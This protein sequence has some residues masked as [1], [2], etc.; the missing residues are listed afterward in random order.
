MSS[1]D[2]PTVA[3]RQLQIKDL[4]NDADAERLIAHLAGVTFEDSLI[5]DLRGCYIDYPATPKVIDSIFLRF[6]THSGKKTLTLVLRPT[7]W[8][9]DSL[10]GIFAKES[11][12]LATFE[13]LNTSEGSQKRSTRKLLADYCKCYNI[14]FQ[15]YVID[16]KD[17]T[18]D[19]HLIFNSRGADMLLNVSQ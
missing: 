19:L 9:L 17:A 10:S 11:K 1:I 13:N 6:Q 4:G 3:V 16:P 5:V 15:L 12:V 2:G 14:V 8:N 7:I 18:L